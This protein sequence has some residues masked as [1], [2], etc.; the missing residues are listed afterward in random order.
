[1][2]VLQIIL[3]GT[4]KHSDEHQKVRTIT[5]FIWQKEK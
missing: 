4:K 3:N 2:K 1:M 5:C